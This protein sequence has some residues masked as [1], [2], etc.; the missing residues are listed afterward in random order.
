MLRIKKKLINLSRH[1]DI[2]INT[3]PDVYLPRYMRIPLYE[4]SPYKKI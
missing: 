3:Y 2:Y 1:I 4:L